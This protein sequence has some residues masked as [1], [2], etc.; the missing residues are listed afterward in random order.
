MGLQH[1]ALNSGGVEG[2][3]KLL[4]L[5]LLY[6]QPSRYAFIINLLKLN[7]IAPDHTQGDTADRCSRS[8]NH[9]TLASLT[10]SPVKL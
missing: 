2:A 3:P 9:L 6:L 7:S 10:S 4:H 5:M 8:C 1:G